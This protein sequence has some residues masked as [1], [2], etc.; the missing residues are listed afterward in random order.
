MAVPDNPQN[1][2]VAAAP[3]SPTKP[4]PPQE[5]SGQIIKSKKEGHVATP[6]TYPPTSETRGE[7]RSQMKKI[8]RRSS[9]PFINWFQRKLAGTVRARRVSEPQ[10]PG[11]R[12]P[13]VQE[14]RRSSVPMPPLLA[15]HAGST[16]SRHQGRAASVG[17][18]SRKNA[19]SLNDTDEAGST[20]DAADSESYDGRRSSLA[21]D[22]TWSPASYYEADED[23]SVRP[24]PPS[25]PPSPSPSRS[26]SSYLSDPRTFRSMAASTKP[27]TLLSV[28]LTGG[29]AHIAQAPPTPTSTSHRIPPYIRS[30]SAGPSGGSISFSA[31]PPPSPT[32]ATSS[33]ALQAPQHT[34]HH[35]RDNPRPDAVPRDDA[36]VLT[37]ASSAFGMPGARIGVAALATSGRAS[38]ADDASHLSAA[39]GASDSTS[40]FLLSRDRY[41]EADDG[42]EQEQEQDRDEDV[43]ASVRALRPRSSRRNS[44]GSE[45][46]KWSAS[47]S[48]ILGS[49]VSP[50]ARDRSLWTGSYRTGAFSVENGEDLE[51][52]ASDEG[53]D[54][55]AESLEDDTGLDHSARLEDRVQIVDATTPPAAQPANTSPSEEP[56]HRLHHHT[57]FTS[58]KSP[59]ETPR[60]VPIPLGEPEPMPNPRASVDVQ[61]MATTDYHTEGY[62]TAASTPLPV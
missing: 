31:L 41:D 27:T 19:I 7:P 20:T 6:A 14:K 12:S 28:D 61:S 42:E 36:S 45:A 32:R 33:G 4:K 1:K 3:T 35:P 15:P 59:S 51:G 49:N 11:T 55:P 24:L 29:M 57:S 40:H 2:P 34:R 50:V 56:V 48:V 10:R 21:R 58:S 26:S 47:A 30:H 53:E 22:S 5:S 16:G 23:A 25:S 18:S 13:S 43:G 60:V 9:K 38:L 46:S 37:L 8:S 44:W 39:H 62:R 54:N 52:E 17:P